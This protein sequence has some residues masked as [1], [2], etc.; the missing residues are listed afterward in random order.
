MPRAGAA[1]RLARPVML[2]YPTPLPILS[3]GIVRIAAAVTTV[4][5]SPKKNPWIKRVAISTPMFGAKIN[6]MIIAAMPS[7]PIKTTALLFCLSARE[8]ESGRAI[9]AAIAIEA[10]RKPSWLSVAEKRRP[11]TGTSG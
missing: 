8:P 2:I 5:H 11:Y 6:A 1:A 7:C 9:N 10:A 3:S 4:E